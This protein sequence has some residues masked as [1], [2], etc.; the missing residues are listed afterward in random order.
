MKEIK[1]KN[2]EEL[3][4]ENQEKQKVIEQLKLDAEQ[5]NTNALT[6]LDVSATLYETLLTLQGG[7]K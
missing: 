4:K 3:E 6:A 5:A 2:L 7:T 1:R